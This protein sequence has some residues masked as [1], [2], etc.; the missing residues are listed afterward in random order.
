MHCKVFGR[1]VR[2]EWLAGT[3]SIQVIP[4][5]KPNFP[6]TTIPIFNIFGEMWISKGDYLFLFVYKNLL[7][8]ILVKKSLFHH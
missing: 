3:G 5:K 7:S 8:A 4:I 6:L 1:E 2:T